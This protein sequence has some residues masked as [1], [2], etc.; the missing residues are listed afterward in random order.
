MAAK[1]TRTCSFC[2]QSSL[3]LRASACFTTAVLLATSIA[4]ANNSRHRLILFPKLSVGQTL[5]YQVAYHTEKQ[6]RT[7]S[8]VVMANAPSGAAADVRGLLRLEVLGVEKVGARS[9][10]H[11]RTWFQFLDSTT[12]I[13]V[14][15][16][17][18]TPSSQVQKQDPKGIAIE[19]SLLPDGRVDQ[20][21][22]LDA[23]YPEQQQAWQQWVERF[24]AAAA[25]PED[26]VKLAQKWKSE[27]IERSPAPITNLVWLRE[28][29]YL[30]DE[31][32]RASQLTVEGDRMESGEPPDTCAVIQTTA[33]L[34]QKSSAKD[35]TPE[36][37]KLHQLR[38]AGSARGANKTL[39]FISTQTGLLVRS[40]DLADQL[41]AVTIAKADGSNRVHY[42]I[43]AKSNTEIFRIANSAFAAP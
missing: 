36:D 33:T 35:A 16:N 2:Q 7:Q 39:L 6:A 38:T 34:K 22:G 43:H 26:G 19:F 17:I 18:P 9:V 40:S 27:E 4:W 28:S 3:L 37:Y 13:K 1:P 41:M 5:T 15:E 21:K 8:T 20:M 25:F 23:L 24:A 30:R 11:A 29:I 31:P 12:Q 32:C 14:P 42:D 10:I